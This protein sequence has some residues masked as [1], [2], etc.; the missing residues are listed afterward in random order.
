MHPLRLLG[1]QRVGSTLRRR[2]TA[3]GP[4]ARRQRMP[5][6]P[7]DPWDGP[8]RK[9]STVAENKLEVVL[10]CSAPRRAAPGNVRT[11]CSGRDRA[12][13]PAAVTSLSVGVALDHGEAGEH[14]RRSRLGIEL[15]GPLEMQEGVG[16]GR[17]SRSP[18]S[19]RRARPAPRPTR[20]TT[21]SPS[22]WSST[23][24]GRRP[25]PRRKG[26]APPWCRERFSPTASRQQPRPRSPRGSPRP[27]ATRVTSS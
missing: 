20:T 5:S 23:S 10:A 21:C 9:P 3:C 15:A 14:Q 16:A 19:R 25:P 13:P 24:R 8:A 27:S 6:R 18:C 11:R 1:Q 4:T 26:S 7:A 17:P 2:P 12:P 22:R